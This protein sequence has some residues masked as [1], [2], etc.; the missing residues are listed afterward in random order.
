[1]KLAF[2]QE[3]Q[4]KRSSFS[5]C[6]VVVCAD[7]TWMQGERLTLW[8]KSKGLWTK[9]TKIA[10]KW[11]KKLTFGQDEGHLEPPFAVV[12]S[13]LA[14][15]MNASERSHVERDH[16]GESKG[17]N[18]SGQKEQNCRIKM[19]A[20]YFQAGREAYG[21]A[22]SLPLPL[23]VVWLPLK[24]LNACREAIVVSQKEAII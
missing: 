5:H 11:W 14:S 21:L 20:T 22:F 3:V 15:W 4:L 7:W 10:G 2:V 17:S 1:M 19:N 13:L 23:A 12:W 16:R 24:A 9:S 18:Y 8:V 6:G